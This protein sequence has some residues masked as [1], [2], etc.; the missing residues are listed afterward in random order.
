MWTHFLASKQQMNG[1]ARFRLFGV[2]QHVEAW[3]MFR[4][5]GSGGPETL[6]PGRDREGAVCRQ[7]LRPTPQ[8]GNPTRDKLEFPRKGNSR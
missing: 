5:L 2:H 8:A 7:L 4:S 6:I 1:T 3:G